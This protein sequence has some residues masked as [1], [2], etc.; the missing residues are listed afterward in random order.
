MTAARSYVNCKVEFIYEQT[1]FKVQILWQIWKWIDLN[2]KEEHI[3]CK[4]LF[5]FAV[6]DYM[7]FWHAKM[8]VLYVHIA[9]TGVHNNSEIF[10]GLQ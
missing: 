9:L 1:I 10:Y 4:L 6:R 8:D 5:F 2:V 3:Y 7:Y